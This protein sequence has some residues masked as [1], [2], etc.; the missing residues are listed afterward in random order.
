MQEITKESK[1]N[2]SSRII[3]E[4]ESINRVVLSTL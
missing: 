3:N 4:V 2:Y 1:D